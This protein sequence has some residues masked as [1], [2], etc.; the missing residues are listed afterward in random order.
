MNKLLSTTAIALLFG[1]TAA[2]AQAPEKYPLNPAGGAS[3]PAYLVPE[4]NP[5]N[6]TGPTGPAYLVESEAKQW[7]D[8]PIYSSDDK[9][10][11]EVRAL[12]RDTAGNVTELQADIGGFL[13]LGKSHVRVTPAQ[14]KFGTDRVILSMTS[15]QAK[16]LP[17]L[18]N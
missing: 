1:A 16:L 9:K 18:V 13:G 10:I 17:K 4:K 14:F 2:M 12:I 7:I 8:K 5:L 3:G 15:E 6:P 11:G